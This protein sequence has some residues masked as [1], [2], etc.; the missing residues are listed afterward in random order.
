LAREVF[1]PFKVVFVGIPKRKKIQ[2]NTKNI[3]L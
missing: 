1:D 3:H 2:N